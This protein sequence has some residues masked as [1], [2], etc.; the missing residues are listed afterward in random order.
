MIKR[1]RSNILIHSYLY[2]QL[3]SPLITDALYDSM[4]KELVEIGYKEI[5]WYDEQ[6]KDFDGSTGYHLQY[7]A[8]VVSKAM[9]IKRLYGRINSL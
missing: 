8:W 2:Y 6:F 3:D 1:L 4:C 9:E 5:G 7:D